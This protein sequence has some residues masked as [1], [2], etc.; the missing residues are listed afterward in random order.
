[1]NDYFDE[2]HVWLDVFFALILNWIFV[3][4]DVTLIV[5]PEG[6]RMLLLESKL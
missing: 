1:M 4:L 5:T 2:V 3:N 6:D